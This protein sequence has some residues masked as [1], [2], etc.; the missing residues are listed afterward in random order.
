MSVLSKRL[1]RTTTIAVAAILPGVAVLG[2]LT[3]RAQNFGPDPNQAQ[4]S[5]P[6]SFAQPNSQQQ[7]S[8]VSGFFAPAPGQN[9]NGFNTHGPGY[10]GMAGRIPLT[11]NGHSPNRDDQ[12][13]MELAAL[14]RAATKGDVKMPSEELEKKTNE[15]S[16]IVNKQFDKRHEEQSKALERAELDAKKLRQTLEA[17]LAAKS[18]IVERRVKQL[19]GEPD[20]MSWDPNPSP[21]VAGWTTFSFPAGAYLPGPNPY[22][23]PNQSPFQSPFMIG[24]GPPQAAYP[25]GQGM[26][27]SRAVG[28]ANQARS[29][30]SS[31]FGLRISST[32]DAEGTRVQAEP[33]VDSMG[34]ATA[35]Q[36]VRQQ[37][38]LNGL[39]SELV[40]QKNLKAKGFIPQSEVQK[41]EARI[42]ALEA[43]NRLLEMHL[44]Q[45]QQVAE[46]R[47]KHAEQSLKELR[48]EGDESSPAL[49]EAMRNLELAQINVANIT[50]VIKKVEQLGVA[51]TDNPD[52]PAIEE[53]KTLM[54][55]LGVE[56]L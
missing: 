3:A 11:N 53:A 4:N 46:L 52:A 13:A 41:T 31:T 19:V 37:I 24:Q 5:F 10:P 16:E 25:S 44:K 40:Q 56:K 6:K 49:G 12:V 23:S 17:R 15:L 18:E 20:P 45:S 21:A 2:L 32:G 39:Q 55:G 33:Q 27:P 34:F 9:S 47:L 22:G 54:K 43:S 38:E 42:K 51:A 8:T 26:Q 50:E 7:P 14:L 48:S 36:Y 35:E 1:G 28:P 29:T 30:T